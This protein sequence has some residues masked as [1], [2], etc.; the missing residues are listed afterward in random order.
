MTRRP[1]VAVIGAGAP[2]PVTEAAARAAGRAVVDAGWRVVCG[3]RGGVMA[4]VCEGARASDRW[5]E[6]TTIGLLPGATADDANPW[7]D[8]ALPT[9][10]GLGRNLLV[11]LA[12]DAVLA[13]GGGSG[14]LS[15]LALAWQHDRP[16]VALDTGAGWATTL[17]GAALD[18]RPR[19]P[20]ARAATVDEAVALLTACLAA[21]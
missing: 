13:I 21:R 19:P 15:E 2:D 9:S 16:I 12:G 1:C 7:V 5:A 3:G 18:D 20:I 4:A 8:V 6:G 14:T 10:L 17:A 11:V